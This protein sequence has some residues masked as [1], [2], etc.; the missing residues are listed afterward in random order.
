MHLLL[1]SNLV[2]SPPKKLQ[3]TIID[4]SKNIPLTMLFGFVSENVHISCHMTCHPFPSA[5]FEKVVKYRG[6]EFHTQLID[7]AG[8]VRGGGNIFIALHMYN[9]I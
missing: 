2:N 3:F 7:T 1:C 4:N 9:C 8:Q 6:Q 5:A